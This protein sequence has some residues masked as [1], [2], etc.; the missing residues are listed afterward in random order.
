MPVSEVKPIKK[1]LESTKHHHKTQRK[2]SKNKLDVTAAVDTRR[3][4]SGER[5]SKAEKSKESSEQPKKKDHKNEVSRTRTEEEGETSRERVK[6]PKLGE[7]CSS[8]QKSKRTKKHHSHDRHES[9]RK[10]VVNGHERV[11]DEMKTELTVKVNDDVRIEAACVSTG[12]Q[13]KENES[14][15]VNGNVN[16]KPPN[17]LVYA[18]SVVA[19]DNVKNVLHAI[20]NNHKYVICKYFYGCNAKNYFFMFQGIQCM[21]FQ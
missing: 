16:S 11:T 12:V 15:N 2:E 4:K 8:E 7:C 19:R 17:V 20:L 3:Q 14:T 18:D 1:S 6:A 10:N 5:K 13:S 9:H 21:I